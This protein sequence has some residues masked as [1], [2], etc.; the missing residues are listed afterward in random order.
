MLNF[1]VKFPNGEWKIILSESRE[2]F[3]KTMLA[4]HGP[5]WSTKFP[6]VVEAATL[7][8]ICDAVKSKGSISF[9]LTLN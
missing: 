8:L 4:E 1:F 7:E 6:Y 5:D 9:P 3:L 2:V